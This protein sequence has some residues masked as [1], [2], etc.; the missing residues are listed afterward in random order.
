LVVA[1]EVVAPRHRGKLVVVEV[2]VEGPL[3]L[4]RQVVLV[5]QDKVTQV[6]ATLVQLLEHLVVVQVLQ[7]TPALILHMVL[8]AA[9][10]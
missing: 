1:A 10:V 3:I 6:V 9:L 7:V 4:V 2:P 5:L 8:M